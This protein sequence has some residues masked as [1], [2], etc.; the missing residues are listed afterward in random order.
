M[1]KPKG[2]HK[3]MT[4]DTRQRSDRRGAPIGN[5]NAAKQRIFYFELMRQ[6]H[7]NPELLPKVA[8]NLIR[9]AVD[10]EPWAIKEFRDTLDGKPAQA[11]AITDSEGGSILS[12]LVV[13]YVK[14]DADNT[15]G[16]T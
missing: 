10:G 9:A 8:K 12:S 11:V 5:K 2:S 15:T 4:Q 7:A 3:T 14:S 16:Q 1:T 13:Q 6:C